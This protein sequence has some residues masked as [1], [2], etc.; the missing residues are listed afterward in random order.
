[1]VTVTKGAAPI[2][3]T[4]DMDGRF[5]ID[6][7]PGTYS[8]SAELQGFRTLAKSLKVDALPVALDL[9][10]ELMAV[11]EQVLVTAG[12]EQPVLSDSRAGA[13][14]VI[15]REV[16]DTAILP[17]NTVFDVL[18]LLPNVVRGPDGLISVAGARAPQGQLLIDGLSQNDPVLGE[19]AVMLP[20]E[21]VHSVEVLSHGYPTQFGRASGGVTIVS[22]RPISD[23]LQFDANSFDPRLH[24]AGGGIRGI[25][26]WEPNLGLSGPI[27]KGRL[28]FTQ[29][30]DYRFLRNSFE[31]V[32]GDEETRYNALLSWSAL[33]LALTPSHRISGWFSADPQRIEHDNINAFTLG[34][35]LP[36]VDRGGLRGAVV[37]RRV[38]G[39]AT[40]V[41]TGVQV[42]NIKTVIEPAGD[43]P[44]LMGHDLIRGNYFDSQDRVASR[45]ELSQTWT[46]SLGSSGHHLL[47][48]G[49]QLA[50]IAFD[51]T[52][53]SGRVE[54]FRSDGTLARSIEFLGSAMPKASGFEAALFAQDAWDLSPAVAVDLGVRY[55]DAT[56]TRARVIAPRVGAT[57]KID[58]ETTLAGGVGVFSDKVLLAAAAFPSLEERQVTEFDATGT[59]A[60][61]ARTYVNRFAAPLTLPR[62][63]AWHAQLD[64]RFGSGL[65]ARLAY[66]ERHGED[67]PVIDVFNQPGAEALVLRSDGTSRARSL[68]TT[69]GYRSAGTG[70]SIYVSYVRSSSIG[71]LNDFVT[72]EGTSKEPFVQPDEVGPLSADVPNRLLAWGMAK[73][74]HRVTIAPFLELRNG[75]PYSAIG[76]DWRD[77]GPR[78]GRR[79]PMFASLDLVINKIMSLPGNLPNAK[80][81]LKFYNLTNSFDGR[82]IQRDIDRADYGSVYNPIR[83][84]IRGVF[85]LL[86]GK[87]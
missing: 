86:W 85:E 73:L 44:Y 65:L 81:G 69:V 19:S 6:L 23:Q 13:P 21:A 14:A 63:N 64:R 28:W 67:E 79:F 35:A 43:L 39:R 58:G 77:V 87:K 70:Q 49:G 53:A 83:R 16:I 22:M 26:A 18:P 59:V 34:S 68:E 38:L 50:R 74:P 54:Q 12:G 76:D 1:V 60:G 3:A 15:T 84:Q 78:N 57:W 42:T 7:P 82:D 55:D 80:I 5:Q 40:T 2:T 66:Q 33:D 46:H 52:N 45:A 32:A 29:G 11:T 9:T 36:K 61:P 31:T 24:F 72:I 51:G 62:A 17:N 25:E 56:V 30:L 10:M 27:V 20:L 41:E 47:K 37:D 75:F 8:L 48:V 4:T 71:N